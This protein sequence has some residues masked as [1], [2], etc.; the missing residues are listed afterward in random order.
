MSNLYRESST[1]AS[2]QVSVHCPFP[3]SGVQLS[4]KIMLHDFSVSRARYN[5]SI[6]RLTQVICFIVF[7]NYIVFRSEYN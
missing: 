4:Y 6:D 3:L 1:D 2:Y 5:P 7:M